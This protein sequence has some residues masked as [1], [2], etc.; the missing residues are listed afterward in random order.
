[1]PAEICGSRHGTVAN[2]PSLR[3]VIYPLRGICY[4]ALSSKKSWRRRQAGNYHFRRKR[5][6][7]RIG[8]F[9]AAITRREIKGSK[10]EGLGHLIR[11]GL[12]GLR[13]ISQRS[14]KASTSD[15]RLKVGGRLS[16]FYPE[17]RKITSNQFILDLIKDGYKIRF[18]KKPPVRFVKTLMP[19]DREA[20]MALQELLRD[21]MDRN[22][23]KEVP[24]QERN[25]GFYSRIFLIKKPT[26]KFRMILN[27]KPLNPFIVYEKFRMETVYTMRNLLNA[28]VF[29]VNIDLTDAYWHIPI[30]RESQKYLRFSVQGDGG[31]LHYQFSCLPFGI[32]SAPRVF[33]KVMAEVVGN[34][35]LQNIIIIPYLDDLLVLADNAV[36]LQR[37]L[38]RVLGQLETLGW[39]VNYQKSHLD[40]SQVIKFL[41]F[42]INSPLQRLFLPEDKVTKVQSTIVSLLE[43]D[44]ISVRQCMSIVGLLTSTAPAVDWAMAHVRVL[45]NWLLENEQKSG[46]FRKRV[47]NT[48]LGKGI[49]ALVDGYKK[50]S[51]RKTMAV[52]SNKDYNNR[53]KFDGLGSPCG[54]TIPARVMD[55]PSKGRV[56]Q[57]QRNEGSSYGPITSIRVSKGASSSGSFRQHNSSSLSEQTRR[58]KVQKTPRSVTEDLRLGRAESAIV[59]SSPSERDITSN[60]R[61]SKQTKTVKFRAEAQPGSIQNDNGQMGVAR[62][63]PFCQS[64]ELSVQKVFLSRSEGSMCNRCVGPRLDLQQSI[65]LSTNP[66]DSS[67]I[68]EVET[69]QNDSDINST[70]LAKTIMVPVVTKNAEKRSFTPPS[71]GITFRSRGTQMGTC[72]KSASK[73]VVSERDVLKSKGLSD[74]VIKTVLNSRKKVTRSIYSKYWKTFL[75]WK[76][77]NK[78]KD[79]KL[80]TILE[81]LQDGIERGLALSTIKVQVAAISVFVDKKLALDPLVIRFMKSVERSRPI[82]KK[83][84]PRW[85]LSLVLNVLMEEPFEPLEE[86]SLRNLT[87]KTIF[88]VAITSA[89]RVSELEALSSDE[90]FCSIFEDRVILKTVTD[91]FTKSIISV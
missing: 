37:D 61:P 56:I 74:R 46:R 42:I 87:I 91:F 2:R 13:C 51:V 62:N 44:A 69:V 30:R 50:S 14:P 88:L 27:L 64:D 5:N 17:W 6:S 8:P 67:C 7:S 11:K 29:M 16:R 15:A 34:L 38:K 90:Q 40:P 71:G 81:F 82:V 4:L 70:R 85:D 77:R 73:S 22:V 21:M 59:N 84:C 33:T 26:G 32:S 66:L 63:R 57:L 75:D 54:R 24:P 58:D 83:S 9:F 10:K 28:D 19:K 60:G 12:G 53:R 47:I 55:R 41:G 25:R 35:H 18:I 3:H 79:N 86:I 20:R 78:V 43:A 1:M 48:N 65:C 52:S 39:L 72:S 23:I 76:K 49:T 68:T 31:V 36:L 89:K 80:P 45:Q